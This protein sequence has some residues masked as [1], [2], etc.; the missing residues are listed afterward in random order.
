TRRASDLV[1]IDHCYRL[2]TQI[3]IAPFNRVRLWLG[4]EHTQFVRTTKPFSHQLLLMVYKHVVLL[5]LGS[6]VK[7]MDALPKGI[8]LVAGQQVLILG[9]C[10]QTTLGIIKKLAESS[11]PRFIQARP[12][13]QQS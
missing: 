6:R 8:M 3:Y 5:C 13:L 10:C 2:I 9:D 12:M 7:S 11:I 4:N 1:V